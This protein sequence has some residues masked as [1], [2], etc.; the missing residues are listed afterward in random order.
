MDDMLVKSVKGNLHTTDLLKAFE[1]LRRQC[2]RLNPTKCAFGVKLLAKILGFMVTKM[3]IEA[4]L[5]KIKAIEEMKSLICHKEIQSLNG[6][7][8][9]LNRFLSKASDPSLPFFQIL[10]VN[11]RFELTSECKAAV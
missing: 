1:C 8:A 9:G 4:K 2:V 10:K 6:R 11:R 3:G 5:E 7:L